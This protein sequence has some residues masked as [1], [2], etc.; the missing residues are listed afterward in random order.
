MKWEKE[1]DIKYHSITPNISHVKWGP[2]LKLIDCT[3]AF[4]N[5][6]AF[7]RLP[8]KRNSS[9]GVSFKIC[10]VVPS[11]MLKWIRQGLTLIYV[12][13]TEYRKYKAQFVKMYIYW[14]DW[15]C[16][17]Q[18]LIKYS[19]VKQI[20]D[21]MICFLMYMIYK[22]MKSLRYI[23]GEQAWL[24]TFIVHTWPKEQSL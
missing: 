5:S 18:S 21:Q 22:G 16:Q 24:P 10:F 9:S 8:L 20:K 19:I 15:S 7:I 2:I 6:S 17:K 1:E 23:K 14:T 12:P 3:F 13:P 11:L 4:F